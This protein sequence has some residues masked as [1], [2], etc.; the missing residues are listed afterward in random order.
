MPNKFINRKPNRLKDYDYSQ[1]GYYFITISTKN[2]LNYFGEV[3]DSDIFLNNY[4]IIAEKYWL[5]IPKYYENVGIDVYTIMPNHV[6]GILIIKDEPKKSIE[7]NENYNGNMK[8]GT[9]SKVINSYKNVVTKTIKKEVNELNFGWHRSYYDHV[10]R[11]EESLAKIR[12]Y[13]I[14]NPLKL[15]LDKSLIDDL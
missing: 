9:I 4:G 6:H 13:I 1:A 7:K 5:N 14:Q 11:D 8:Y 12:E 10:V 15:F 3:I 2:N